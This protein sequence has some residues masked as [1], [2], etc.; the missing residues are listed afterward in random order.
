VAL[1]VALRRPDLVGR[2]VFVAGVFD[3]RGWVAG[4]IDPDNEPPEFMAHSYGEVSPDGRDHFALV[5]AKLDQM[6]L[7]E[8][9]LSTGSSGAFP[10]EPW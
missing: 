4:V 1:L 9:T 3:L 7:E 10:R 5:A 2:L 8:P 6:H